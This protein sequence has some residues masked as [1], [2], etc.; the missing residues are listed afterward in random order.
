LSREVAVKVPRRGQFED[1]GQEE[2]F[3]REARMTAQLRHPGIVA[4][5]DVGR[6]RNTVYL[7]ADLVHG[8][9][10][11][12]WLR[13]NRPPFRQAAEWTAGIAEAVEFAHQHGVIHRDLKPSNILISFSRPSRTGADP[14]AFPMVT[15]FGLA[16]REAGEITMTMEG[17]VLGTPA[18]MSPEQI[19]DPHSVDARGDV[20]SIGC[21][22]YEMLTGELPFRGVARMV[23]QQVLD[24]D[25]RPPRG[26]NDKIPRELETI[27]LK[28]LAKETGQRYQTA[29]ELSAELRRWLEGVPIHARPTGRLARS[30]RWARRKPVVAGLALALSVAILGGLIATSVL[31]RVAEHNR[32]NWQHQATEANNLRLATEHEL[33]ESHKILQDYFA[34]QRE[35]DRNN[36]R[37]DRAGLRLGVHAVLDHW[38]RVYRQRPRDSL[39]RNQLGI[40]YVQ[41]AKMHSDDGAGEE[42][43]AAYRR[44]A[45]LFVELSQEQPEI[46]QFKVY[47]FN[48]HYNSGEH[49]YHLNRYAEAVHEFEIAKRL[50]IEI[51]RTD[52]HKYLPRFYI[53]DSDNM[54]G[55]VHR[56]D[57][58]LEEAF[59]H[60]LAA[61]D[62]SLELLRAE[63]DVTL[64]QFSLAKTDANLGA[65]LERVGLSAQIFSLSQNDHARLLATAA[66]T[67]T[68]AYSVQLTR[69]ACEQI[70]KLPPKDLASFPIAGLLGESW[71]VLG[72]AAQRLGHREDGIQA[73][74]N[75]VR[76]MTAALIA[77]PLSWY[78]RIRANNYSEHLA[79][80]LLD[81]GRIDEA[82][83]VALERRQWAKEP[84]A[85]S[86]IALELVWCA[87]LVGK[88]ST[89]A[90]A[91]QE[92]ADQ[93]IEALRQAVAN[94]YDNLEHLKTNDIWNAVRD[95][96]DFQALVSELEKRAGP[97]GN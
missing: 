12:E 58:R 20:Y 89:N 91:R 17:Q 90:A 38:E 79:W 32:E 13:E 53:A 43:I 45:A 94:G 40:S 6:D 24:E 36:T 8:T 77:H 82:A 76:F 50:A 33:S 34:V 7:V 4:V 26:L 35:L 61:R 86:R 46:P 22:L 42:A 11:A 23:L 59:R 52:F 47:V 64:F 87:H 63:P 57:G 31:W 81:A 44:A 28:C 71:S 37:G 14:V 56:L 83:K 84:E 78:H 1:A 66:G 60:H 5:H 3:L 93:G 72:D 70:E 73:Y 75:A 9:S 97:N 18:Y 92:Y 19:R 27:T 49:L 16:K 62:Y 96:S 88:D 80:R 10:L 54:I 21:M 39:V 2:R 95:R 67:A 41:L 48:A 69:N 65:T 74:R 25:P 85:L 30:W 68:T 51:S 29:T 55:V 15:D